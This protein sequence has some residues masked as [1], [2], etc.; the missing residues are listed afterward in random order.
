MNLAVIRRL[1]SIG[2]GDGLRAQLVR[3]AMGV[4]GLKLL[5]L[6]LTLATSI[7]LARALGPEGYGQYVFVMA[8]IALLALPIGP[9]LGQL[10]T[11]EVARYH[12]GEDWSLFRGLLRRAHQWVLLGSVV[13]I[14]AVVI[15]AGQNATWAVDDRWTLLFI[16]SLML[17]LLGLNALRSHTLR[18]L[19]HVFQAQLPELLARPAFH[20]VF[21]G[22]LLVGGALTPASALGS[23]IAATGLAFL[24]GAWLLGRYRPAQIKQ[25]D[26]DYRNG[27]W[28]RALLPFTLLAAVS[29]L[30]AQIGILAL[31]WL[32]TDE[33]IAALK[34]AQQG[35]MLV[36]LSLT[37]VNLVIGPH[38]TGAHRDGNHRR[39]QT[40]SRASARVALIFSSVLALPMLVMP[41]VVLAWV[42][43]AEY[44]AIASLPLVIL[45]TAQLVNVGFGA[46]G[47]LLMMTGNEKIIVSP[48][49]FALVV[50]GGLCVVLIPKLGALGAAVAAAVSIVSLNMLL[51]GYVSRMLNLRPGPF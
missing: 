2:R 50:N 9:G 29:T 49:L 41:S 48:H 17:P 25:A 26:P 42:F 8:V 13:I 36:L 31:G 24:L 21:A 43:G 30:N 46:V 39:L 22:V 27:E 51:A 35:A 47:M 11:R 7:L 14:G 19:R 28:G 32:G 15:V 40:L 38:I 34:L 45:V 18:G 20:L 3:G 1:L 16:A 44:A 5:G 37:I 10:V 4:G 12:H 33:D 6:P 23:Q